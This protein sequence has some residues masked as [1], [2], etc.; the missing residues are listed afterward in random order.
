MKADPTQQTTLR[1]AY[2]ASF[3]KLAA[4]GCVEPIQTNS[5]KATPIL[6]HLVQAIQIKLWLKW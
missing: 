1:S 6:S 4:V 3:L 5:L 2:L